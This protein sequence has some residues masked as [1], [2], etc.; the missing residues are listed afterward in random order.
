M[1]YRNILLATSIAA[2]FGIGTPTYAQGLNLDLGAGA[3]IGI[4]IGI[5]GGSDSSEES[6]AAAGGAVAVEAGGGVGVRLGGDA[7]SGSGDAAAIANADAAIDLVIGLIARSNWQGN[8]FDGEV[9]VDGA[10]AFS[11]AAWLRAETEARFRAAVEEGWD[12]IQNLQAAIA[13]SA[14]LSAWLQGQGFNVSSVVAVAVDA[15]GQ[16][17]AFAM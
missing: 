13:A 1:I 15:E 9:T 5:S 8:E 16:L 14:T 11:V 10:Q 12:Q 3:E 2:A 6:G 4:G 17:M 7:G